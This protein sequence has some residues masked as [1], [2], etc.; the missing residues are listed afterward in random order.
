MYEGGMG[1]DMKESEYLQFLNEINFIASFINYSSNNIKLI[2]KQF[3]T[4][5]HL[6]GASAWSRKFN[7]V[8]KPEEKYNAIRIYAPVKIG[9]D[10][11]FKE[12]SVYDISQTTGD[13]IP[14]LQ[15]MQKDNHLFNALKDLSS[16]QPNIQNL[17]SI[18]QSLSS[19]AIADCTK[20]PT[21]DGQLEC[22]EYV[23]CLYY[24]IGTEHIQMPQI[25]YFHMWDLV[26][27][28]RE[29]SHH[30]IKQI[31]ANINHQLSL[32]KAAEEKRDKSKAES[33]SSKDI[34]SS[35]SDKE[36]ENFSS[37]SPKESSLE[38]PPRLSLFQR[39]ND[40]KNKVLSKKEPQKSIDSK[41]RELDL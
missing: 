18:I 40:A 29:P 24:G 39:L 3:P 8:V 35:S 41:K 17:T 13:L 11:E 33:C 9:G 25:D 27:S 20:Y 2:H 16:V 22:V 10:V 21:F 36:T 28:I 31:D 4:A 34:L 37:K 23:I 32:E 6:E 1:V 26:P 5:T 15:S 14:T 30:L 38:P 19:K 12:V 7:R